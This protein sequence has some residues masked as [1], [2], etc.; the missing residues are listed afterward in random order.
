VIGRLQPRVAAGMIGGAC[1]I[2][3]FLFW[4]PYTAEI[5]SHVRPEELASTLEWHR[6][7]ADAFEEYFLP[8]TPLTEKLTQVDGRIHYTDMVN[9]YLFDQNHPEIL[10]ERPV[11]YDLEITR[12]FQPIHLKNYVDAYYTSIMV[13]PAGPSTAEL[14]SPWL[15]DTRFP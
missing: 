5:S 9:S 2:E 1:L 3:L 11:H 14:S 8:A 4:Q 7:D 13:P 6:I 15:E 10:A 12:G